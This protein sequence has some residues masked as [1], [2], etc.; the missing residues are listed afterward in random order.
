MTPG[1]DNQKGVTCVNFLEQYEFLQILG[2]GAGSRVYLAR[3][4][5]LGTL[6][7]IKVLSKNHPRA[8]EF[9]KE[10]QIL[11]N[12]NHPGIPCI[13][14]VT[15]DSEQYY[16]IE[17]YIPGTSLQTLI[18]SVPEKIPLTDI[19][20]YGMELCE[21]LSYLHKQKPYPLL[22]LDFKPEHVICSGERVYLLDFGSVR[23][24]RSWSAGAGIPG[25]TGFVS[26]EVR[27]GQF[28]RISSDIYGVGAL[29][30]YMTTGR[31]YEGSDSFKGPGLMDE[32]WK[33]VLERCLLE[34][35]DKRYPDM[36]S[37]KRDLKKLEYRGRKRG[38]VPSLTI[39]VAGAAGRL[40]VTHTAIGLTVWLNRKRP[41]ALYLDETETHMVERLAQ[42]VEG[43]RESRGIIRIGDFLGMPRFGSGVKC[44]TDDFSIRILDLGSLGTDWKDDKEWGKRQRQL[45]MEADIVLLLLGSRE[46]EIKQSR[47]MLEQWELPLKPVILFRFGLTDAAKRML[48]E[49]KIRRFYVIPCFWQLW[50]LEKQALHFYQQLWKAIAGKEP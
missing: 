7:A 29:L 3:H 30:Y 45:C 1:N 16:L 15:E 35:M 10:A 17:E 8:C 46:W 36:P 33:A 48:M 20:R 47:T 38:E 18:S 13:Y 9:L 28:P 37:L 50:K 31:L 27:A 2:Q 23:E 11:Q 43:A 22:Y 44:E 25:T 42:E 5:V 14:E 34:D 41:V 26:P 12:L 49:Q 4:K 24:E 40:G 39:V 21:I 32:K 19:I 6:R